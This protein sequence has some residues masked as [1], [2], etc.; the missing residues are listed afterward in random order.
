MRPAKGDGKICTWSNG[1][2]GIV[3]MRNRICLKVYVRFVSGDAYAKTT[4]LAVVAKDLSLQRM[5]ILK[6]EVAVQGTPPKP[7]RTLDTGRPEFWRLTIGTGKKHRGNHLAGEGN[8]IHRSSV[9]SL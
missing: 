8:G 9:Y 3:F 7:H 6:A 4:P 2:N 5:Q 1:S